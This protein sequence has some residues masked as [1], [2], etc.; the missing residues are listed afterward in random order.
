MPAGNGRWYFLDVSPSHTALHLRLH[1]AASRSLQYRRRGVEAAAHVRSTVWAVTLSLSPGAPRKVTLAQS[2]PAGR[3]PRC[4]DDA[5]HPN[6]Q[7]LW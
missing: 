7:V 3:I 1:P 5:P 6:F 4:A 2:P